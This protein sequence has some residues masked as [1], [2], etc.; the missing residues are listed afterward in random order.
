VRTGVRR[1]IF[2]SKLMTEMILRDVSAA[3]DLR[4]VALRYFNVA[5]AWV[6]L[7]SRRQRRH[8]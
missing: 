8:T 7:A 6:G 3:H 4:Y 5:G 1:F 2:S